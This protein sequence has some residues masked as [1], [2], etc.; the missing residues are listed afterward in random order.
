[1]ICFVAATYL[2]MNANKR[3]V[4]FISDRS[5][6]TTAESIRNNLYSHFNNINFQYKTHAFINSDQ[7]AQQVSND[8]KLNYTSTT[9]QPIV[10]STLVDD[11]IQNSISLTS[12]YITKLFY[13]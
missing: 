5:E 10:F 9:Q 8:I 13:K 6:K 7:S 11:E 4:F 1:M 12:A 3:S 2:L